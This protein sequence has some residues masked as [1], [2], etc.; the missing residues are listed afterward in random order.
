MKLR[1]DTEVDI[2]NT[3]NDASLPTYEKREKHDK[4]GGQIGKIES[5]HMNASEQITMTK[6]L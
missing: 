6:R 3:I 1:K 2:T 5:N 4:M